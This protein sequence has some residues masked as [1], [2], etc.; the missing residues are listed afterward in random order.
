[1]LDVGLAFILA[2]M[3]FTVQALARK[4]VTQA[5]EAAA[6]RLYRILIHGI[7]VLL[8]LF[9]LFGDRIVW[10]NGITGLAWRAWLLLYILPWWLGLVRRSPGN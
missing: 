5:V 2:I 8:V 9:F 1:V 3:A 6:Y 4:S 7:F 10:I